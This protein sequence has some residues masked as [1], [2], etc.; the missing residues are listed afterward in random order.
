M[1]IPIYAIIYASCA[2][3]LSRDT[4]LHVFEPLVWK[5]VGCRKSDDQTSQSGMS[6][7]ARVPLISPVTVLMQR[8]PYPLTLNPVVFSDGPLHGGSQSLE[9]KTTL[10]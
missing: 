5:P 10:C 9:I 4:K 7:F 2:C 1:E 6:Y 3:G 8:L